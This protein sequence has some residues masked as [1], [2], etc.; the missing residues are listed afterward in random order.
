M[1]LERL[2]GWQWRDIKTGRIWGLTPPSRQSVLIGAMAFID[3]IRYDRIQLPPGS[4]GLIP[5]P[6]SDSYPNPFWWLDMRLDTTGEVVLVVELCQE[7]RLG[8][9]VLATVLDAPMAGALLEQMS[10]F[11][12]QVWGALS[13]NDVIPHQSL[14]QAPVAIT[15]SILDALKYKPDGLWQTIDVVWNTVKDCF[16]LVATVT[17]TD[18]KL[19]RPL[20]E[21]AAQ[22]WLERLGA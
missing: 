20:S 21:A 22:Q 2:D 6:L 4:E 9:R 15:P 19:W 8:T 1:K 5:Q 13:S 11:V 7:A 10:P 14:L 12:W 3:M 17:C 18:H 16:S